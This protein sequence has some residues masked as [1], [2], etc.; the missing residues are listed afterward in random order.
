[1][2]KALALFLS[3]SF[4]CLG[5]LAQTA[6]PPQQQ[7]PQQPEDDEVVRITSNLVQ[8]DVVVTDKD[9]RVVPD[10]KLS[11]FE[12][13]ENGKK[14]DLKF[15]EYVGVEEGRRAEG[16]RAGEAPGV[17][18]VERELT[19][20]DVRRVIAFVVDDLTIPYADL[21]TVRKI[22][23]DYVDNKMEKGDLVAII[24]VVG[25]KSLLQ[26]FT[27]DKQLLRRAINSITVTPNPYDSFGDQGVAAGITSADVAQGA[28]AAGDTQEAQLANAEV[29]DQMAASI[30]DETTRMTRGL[31]TLSTAIRVTES[32]SQ[33]PGRKTL[34]LF[35]AGIPVLEE[36]STGGMY[37]SLS[38]LIKR[39]SDTALRSGV[40]I[41]T[42]DPRG[43]N[44]SRPV[45]SFADTPARSALDMTP[46][47]GFGRGVSR[48]EQSILG[49]TLAGASE[50]LSLRTLSG[51][52]GGVAVV[53]TNDF[54]EGL[55]R[56][57]ARSRGYY[58]LAYTPT[59]KFDNKFRKLDVRVKRDGVHVYKYSGYI[60]REETHA[61][62]PRTKQE[63]I[64]AAARSPLAKNDVDVSSN[65][66]L[67]MQPPKGAQLGI[68]L[69]IDPKTLSF[70][71][72]DGRYR[73]TFDVVGFIIDEL[74]KTR[75]GFSETVNANLTPADYQEA[76]RSGLT[77][78]ADTQLPPGYF[79]MR[80]VVREDST[81]NLGTVSRYVEVPD[82][83][84][85]RLAMSSIFIHAVAAG[86]ASPVP[87]TAVR[88]LQRNQ[89]LRY[90]AI[91]YNAKFDGGKP[92]LRSQ[93]IITRDG[94]VIFRGAEQQVVQ[95]GNDPSQVVTVDQIGLGRVPAGRYVLTLV[96]ADTQADNKKSPPLTRSIDFELVD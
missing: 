18:E 92:L 31:M 77:Y 26:Q 28:D 32:L 37:F 48:Q 95:R 79:Q 46:D 21:Y 66:S 94:K 1:M 70:T 29:N 64:L 75:G 8:T 84:K 67:K 27:S 2:R 36:G 82:L 23:R 96:V 91:I 39:L 60:A 52:T 74:G 85:G 72:A 87:L 73:A 20:R 88:R 4:L 81:G 10:L 58:L 89:D 51:E 62:A 78:T 49:P 14:Q 15:M 16:A 38:Q 76:L 45:A 55:D 34:V 17:S 7:Q 53:N 5:A 68:N 50:H 61:A 69:L 83:S 63:E 41:N 6:A 9:D 80:A 25:G 40:V 47:A 56:V 11:D 86:G 12:V 13:Y 30:S 93:T 22:L 57:L 3:S 54:K 71:Q 59:E 33:V 44:A 90:S 35:S 65:L 19:Q 43:L 24:R 42:M